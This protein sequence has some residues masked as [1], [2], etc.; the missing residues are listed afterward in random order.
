MVSD[1]FLGFVTLAIRTSSG[2]SAAS[3]LTSRAGHLIADKEYLL[4][5]LQGTI[6]RNEENQAIK[7]NLMVPILT[8][9]DCLHLIITRLGIRCEN[10]PGR[11]YRA[12]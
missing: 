10:Q 3:S 2:V 6:W 9:K 12:F 4:E 8:I 5:H 7:T 11:N 1:S